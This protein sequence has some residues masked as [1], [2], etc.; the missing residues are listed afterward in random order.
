MLA[1]VASSSSEPER[2]N[3]IP[4]ALVSGSRN[5]LSPKRIVQLGFMRMVLRGKWLRTPRWRRKRAALA[6]PAAPLA[7]AGGGAGGGAGG[8]IHLMLAPCSAAASGP[9]GAHEEVEPDVADLL[10]VVLYAVV[11]EGDNDDLDVACNVCAAGPDA[12]DADSDD[13]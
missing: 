11:Q 1:A 6:V 7:T 3:S 4:T 10:D 8:A 5:T 13:E 9:D 2:M 12:V